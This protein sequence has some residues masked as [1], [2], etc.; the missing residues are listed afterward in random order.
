MVFVSVAQFG[1]LEGAGHRA[2]CS[3]N[4][5]DDVMLVA[6]QVSHNT[7]MAYIASE[8]DHDQIRYLKV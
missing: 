6:T 5:K 2:E 8:E 7:T 1:S 4:Q 3:A